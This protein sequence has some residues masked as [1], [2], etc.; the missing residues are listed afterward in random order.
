[1]AEADNDDLAD[2]IGSL[3]AGSVV[4]AAGC[5]KTEQI[6]KATGRNAGRRL[7]LTH[8]HAGVDAL[9]KRMNGCAVP[10]KR[11]S[12]DTIAGRCL[13][14]VASYPFRSGIKLSEPKGEQDWMAIYSAA[15]RLLVSGAV[16]RVIRASYCGVFVDEYQDCGRAQHRVIA[17]LAEILPTCVFGDPMQA[18]FDFAG[19]TPV[20]WDTEVFPR[21]PLVATL[22]KPHR[23]HNHNNVDMANWLENVRPSL[24]TGLPID[25]SEAPPCVT[26]EW[27]PDQDGP[28]QSKIV[29]SCL[30]AMAL[31]GNLLV[32]GDPTNLSGR[33]MIARGL[34]KQGFSNIEPVD[35]KSV[36]TAARKMKSGSDQKR[37]EA[38]LDFLKQ[39]MSG[40]ER[41]DFIKAV[42]S[43]ALGGKLGTAKFG[44][45]LIGLGLA[46]RDGGGDEACLALIEAFQRLPTT[47]TYRQ[48][49]YSAM[50]S[51][52]KMTSVGDSPDL[53][54]AIWEVQNRIRHAGRRISYRSVGSTLLV[55]GLEFSNVIVVHSPNMNR[56]DWYVAITRATHTLKILSPLKRFTP[57]A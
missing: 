37:F 18:I 21:F 2:L 39:C 36:Y 23:W 6:V 20:D 8:T 9:R 48:Q 15:H 45:E 19:Q 3:R 47:Y 10:T 44:N 17:A 25:F 27:L 4:A 54:A 55:K 35:C 14:Y 22:T 38:T 41:A 46:L 33:A 1:M 40:I 56:K 52:L 49:M 57:V 43:R 32:I 28:R 31:D 5:G 12:I 51:A 24:E 29:G 26:W 7:I 34:A 53:R 30:A 50:K 13:R 42:A 16:A 11:F